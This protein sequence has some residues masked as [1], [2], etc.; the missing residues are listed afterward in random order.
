MEPVNWAAFHIAHRDDRPDSKH[1]KTR[2]KEES[3]RLVRV[4]CHAARRLDLICQSVANG[5][6]YVSNSST[7][8]L[9]WKNQEAIC[10]EFG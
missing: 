9:L 7:L 4:P 6:N 5:V 1:N 2:A 8:R 10:G 3:A